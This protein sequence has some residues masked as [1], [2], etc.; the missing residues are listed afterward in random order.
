MPTHM[1]RRKAF[2]AW[3][4][5]QALATSAAF[6]GSAR[7]IAFSSSEREQGPVALGIARTGVGKNGASESA[8][9]QP[10]RREQNFAPRPSCVFG[11]PG[12]RSPAGE[13]EEAEAEQECSR[14]LWNRSEVDG[15]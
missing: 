7:S 9:P 15:Q 10:G 1:K 11:L 3:S 12:L 8:E 4:P 2:V 6:F 5:L 13:R 14:R